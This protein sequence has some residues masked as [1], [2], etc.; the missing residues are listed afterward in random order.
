[1]KKG[2]LGSLILVLVLAF[3]APVWAEDEKDDDGDDKA[4]P[5]AAA[6][7]S[8]AASPAG[9]AAAI[10]AALDEYVALLKGKDYA[11]FVERM[12]PPTA[13]ERK[14]DWDK[15]KAEMIK[16]YSTGSP[17]EQEDMFNTFAQMKGQPWT[18][19]PD[20]KSATV[21]FKAKN[22]EGKEID[23]DGNMILVDGKWY[24]K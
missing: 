20:G 11:G 2:L 22:A 12:T 14:K 13:E 18:V 3:A 15:T 24:M 23:Q 8:P 7:A 5:S 19:A 21:K 4:S 6:P 9:G 10:D 16:A 17:K 1:M